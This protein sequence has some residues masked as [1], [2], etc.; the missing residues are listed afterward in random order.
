MISHLVRIARRQLPSVALV[1][2]AAAPLVAQGP[3]AKLE[4][5]VRDGVDARPVAA[6]RITILGTAFG[7]LTDSSGY[8][9]INGIPAG[10]YVVRATAARGQGLDLD[11]VEVH[12]GG[13]TRQDF[14]LRT[15][16]GGD[17]PVHV[18]GVPIAQNRLLS[19]REHLEHQLVP[20]RYTD[21]APDCS[22]AGHGVLEG[23][24]RDQDHRLLAGARVTVVGTTLSTQTDHLG[25]YRFPAVPLGRHQ[26]RAA[27]PGHQA[28]EIRGLRV[29]PCQTVTLDFTLAEVE[30]EIGVPL[31]RRID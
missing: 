19:G 2:A 25:R 18:D 28:G 14:T 13:V 17:A 30:V 20:G 12:P 3:T 24:A 31:F 7:A 4:G 27:K 16:P 10:S 1:V 26:V 8:Y 5:I 23:A 9:F 22:V 15:P 29:L 6:A 11:S 21:R